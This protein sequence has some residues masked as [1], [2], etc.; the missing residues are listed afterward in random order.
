MITRH[1]RITVALLTLVAMA[2]LAVSAGQ[3]FRKVDPTP[4][5]MGRAIHLTAVYKFNQSGGPRLSIHN[6]T[7]SLIP[8]GTRINWSIAGRTHDPNGPELQV[9]K[10]G[11][12]ILQPGLPT[13]NHVVISEG[14]PHLYEAKPNAWYFK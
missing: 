5:K 4:M 6:S 3:T 8:Q 9:E 7:N 14:L 10:K 11:S 2:S 12:F 1:Y 13:N